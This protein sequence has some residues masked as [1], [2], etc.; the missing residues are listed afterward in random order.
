[1]ILLLIYFFLLTPHQDG[2][3]PKG[4]TLPAAHDFFNTDNLDNVYL[5]RDAEL[6]KYNAQ[7]KKMG[8]YSNLK[9]GSITSVDAMNPLKLLLYYHDYQQVVFLDNQLSPNGKSIPLE[10]IGLEQVSIVCASV[11]NGFWVYDKRNNELV[12]FD[13]T[14]RKI[15]GTG[16]LKQVLSDKIVPVSMREYNNYLYLNCPGAGIYVFDVFGAFTRLLPL[17]GISR[18][19]PEGDIV[20]YY[21]NGSMCSYDQRLLEE[22]CDSIFVPGLRSAGVRA[23]KLYRSYGDSLTVTPL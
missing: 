8:R 9:L 7:G 12:R 21:R 3:E 4:I 22:K 15:T 5:V 14:A 20:F 17:K 16:N 13:E 1:V 10:A 11:N 6:V 2:G 23:H 18:F 19:Q